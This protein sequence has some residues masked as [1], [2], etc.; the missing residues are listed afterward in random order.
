MA[1]QSAISSLQSARMWSLQEPFQLLAQTT[2]HPRL[3]DIDGA[4]TDAELGRHFRGGSVGNDVFPACFPGARLKI[5]LH[6]LQGAANEVLAVFLLA[7]PVGL[8][9]TGELGESRLVRLLGRFGAPLLIAP[10]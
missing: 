5:G 1:L 8:V 2:E 7:H 9:G 3:G 10:F 4:D 6:D